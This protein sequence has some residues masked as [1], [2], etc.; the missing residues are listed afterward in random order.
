[1]LYRAVLQISMLAPGTP[2]FLA[3]PPGLGAVRC[4]A[5]Q[6]LAGGSSSSSALMAA[7]SDKGGLIIARPS[8]NNIVAK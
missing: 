2:A 5:R 6:P 3:L 8:S 7:G 1:V 4:L